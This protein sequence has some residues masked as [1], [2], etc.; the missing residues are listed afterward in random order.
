[1]GDKVFFFRLFHL[2]FFFTGIFN[3][4]SPEFCNDCLSSLQKGVGKT[5]HC[6]VAISAVLTTNLYKRQIYPVM[7]GYVFPTATNRL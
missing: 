7:L 4:Y 5:G 3:L 6:V 2:V 1:M